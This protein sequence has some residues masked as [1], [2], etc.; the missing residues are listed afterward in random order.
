M[1]VAYKIHM[2]WEFDQPG[3]SYWRAILEPF[4]ILVGICEDELHWYWELNISIDEGD[5]DS[6]DY[7]VFKPNLVY[8]NPIEAKHAAEQYFCRMV[9]KW[10]TIKY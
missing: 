3:W 10:P 2:P 5:G 1:G 9:M 8:G 7:N 6:T 4:Y